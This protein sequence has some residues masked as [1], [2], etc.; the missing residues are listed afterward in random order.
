MITIETLRRYFPFLRT[1]IMELNENNYGIWDE[2]G[3]HWTLLCSSIE[4][5][6]KKVSFKNNLIYIVNFKNP[7]AGW[8]KAHNPW[9][10]YYVFFIPEGAYREGYEKYFKREELS[11]WLKSLNIIS[12]CKKL[13][14]PEGDIYLAPPSMYPGKGINSVIKRVIGGVNR[15]SCRWDE[16]L[17]HDG[18]F[19][20]EECYDTVLFYDNLLKEIE[21]YEDICH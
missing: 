4:G 12:H 16:T 19:P 20:L 21:E 5:L 15:Y 6:S 18:F 3:W 2:L 10:D 14:Y 11:E 7:S 1:D 17:R 13:V 8:I 9:S